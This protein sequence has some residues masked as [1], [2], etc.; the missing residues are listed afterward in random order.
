MESLAPPKKEQSA[1]VWME[2]GAG[3]AAP[4][5]KASATASK[6]GRPPKKKVESSDDEVDMGQVDGPTAGRKPRAATSKPV[7]YNTLDSDSDGDD[8]LFDVGKM[9]KGIDTAS[10]SADTSRPLF[11]ASLYRPGSSAGPPKKPATS[12]TTPAVVDD[13]DDT[14]YSML[15]PPTARKGP[16]MTARETILSDDEE[17]SLDNIV[18]APKAKAR[19]APKPTAT[20]APK[21]KA[22][23]KATAAALTKKPSKQP[24]SQLSEPKKLPLS[25]AAKAYAAKKA[26][27]EKL[28]L[29]T[30]N[31][32]EDEVEKIANEIMNDGEDEDEDEEPPAAA[33]AGRRPARRA[34]S[35]APSKKWVISD[36]EDEDMEETTGVFDDDDDDSDD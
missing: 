13:F 33:G 7:K 14:N 26:K 8:M 10:A 22:P 28:A 16:A 21:A 17:D 29:E 27:Q 20:V 34:A 32:S 5:A 6:R 23:P 30:E 25:P 19:Q 9:V 2:L 11:S 18:P 31:D 3:S 1:D 35:A 15:A 12:R 24:A 36:D 4:K